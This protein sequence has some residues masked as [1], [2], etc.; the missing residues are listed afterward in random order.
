MLVFGLIIAVLVLGVLAVSIFSIYGIPVVLLL[1]LGLGA[2]LL[3]G[4]KKKGG[5]SELGTIERTKRHE[6]TGRPRPSTGNTDTANHRQG[7]V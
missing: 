4:S 3:V 7:Q 6:P 1:L 5:L 2:F